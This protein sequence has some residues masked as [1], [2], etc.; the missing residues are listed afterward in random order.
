MSHIH[1]KQL[2]KK[3]RCFIEISLKNKH[4]IRIADFILNQQKSPQWA[5][6]MT[7]CR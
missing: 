2:S 1:Y 5:C 7:C 3:E 4:S 6:L